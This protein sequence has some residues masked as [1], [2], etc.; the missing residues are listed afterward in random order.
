M[1]ESR[2]GD[3]VTFRAFRET[4]FPQLRDWLSRPHVARWWGPD[5]GGIAGAGSAAPTLAAVEARYRP[6][7]AATSRTHNYIV[8]LDGI[9]SCFPAA[10][11]KTPRGSAI[12]WSPIS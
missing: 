11:C 7:L 1:D 9:A 6:L 3:A 4:D 2:P 12:P 10:S 8:L 5:S